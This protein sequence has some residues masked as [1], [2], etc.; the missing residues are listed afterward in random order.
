MNR[1]AWVASVIG[2]AIVFC[3]AAARHASVDGPALLA[4]TLLIGIAAR[5]VNK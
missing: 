3:E 1:D 4:A 5:P 2:A